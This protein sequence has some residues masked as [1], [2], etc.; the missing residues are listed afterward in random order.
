MRIAAWMVFV[1]VCPFPYCQ[2]GFSLV[3]L[4]VVG[5]GGI[6]QTEKSK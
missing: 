3:G 1:F 2:T 4:F 5:T 6:L